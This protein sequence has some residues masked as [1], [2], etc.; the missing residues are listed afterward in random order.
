MGSILTPLA[1]MLHQSAHNR[2]TEAFVSADDFPSQS[3][4]LLLIMIIYFLNVNVTG[5]IKWASHHTNGVAGL[6]TYVY[7]IQRGLDW[8]G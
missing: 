1:M 5:V 3:T 2:A 6:D 4:V 8:F 7:L